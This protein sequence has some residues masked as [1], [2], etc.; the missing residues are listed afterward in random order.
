MHSRCL[1]LLPFLLALTLI[2]CSFAGCSQGTEQQRG[3]PE[4]SS[5]IKVAEINLRKSATS[6]S[7]P[8]YPQTALELNLSG[9]VVGYTEVSKEGEVTSI[10]VK[11]SPSEILSEAVKDAVKKWRFN[12]AKMKTSGQA[13]PIVGEL[14]FYFK[15]EEGRGVVDYP[16]KAEPQN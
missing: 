6:S 14:T 15:I 8:V 3:V 13:V 10:E 1:Q 9:T 7:P 4:V 2:S 5:P 11:E 16:T 12:P